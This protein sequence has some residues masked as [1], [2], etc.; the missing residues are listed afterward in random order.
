MTYTRNG[1]TVA[2]PANFSYYIGSGGALVLGGG[3]FGTFTPAYSFDRVN[4]VMTMQNDVGNSFLV[5]NGGTA[6]ATL[7]VYNLT[8]VPEP[9]SAALLLAGL[10]GLGSIGAAGARRRAAHAAG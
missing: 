6:T 2:G 9:A 4:Y 8:P 10:L 3:S 5:G 7:G 1:A